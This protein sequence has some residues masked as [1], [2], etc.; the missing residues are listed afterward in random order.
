MTEKANYDELINSLNAKI[1]NLESRIQGYET[2][3]NRNLTNVVLQQPAVNV[4]KKREKALGSEYKQMRGSKLTLARIIN[5]M[6]GVNYDDEPI[7]S[8]V[9]KIS[10]EKDIVKKDMEKPVQKR[11]RKPKAKKNTSLPLL[12]N[13][14]EEVKEVK[15]VEEVLVPNT[16][17]SAKELKKEKAAEKKRIAAEK[18]KKR[19]DKKSKRTPEQQKKID[20]RMAKI[21]AAR[22]LKKV[23]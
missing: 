8:E 9:T 1:S 16:T 7:E 20:E 4:K 17:K 12:D 23:E 15:K 13:K 5:E 2:K 22:K 11:G 21:R 6:A 19:E 3:N 18:K 10:T 14:V